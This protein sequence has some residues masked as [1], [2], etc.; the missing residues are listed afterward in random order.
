MNTRTIEILSPAGS[1]EAFRAAINAGADAVYAG[2]AKFGA[3][4][5]AEN[6][7]EE[8][9]I[10]AIKEA[11]IYGKKFY[12]T[13]N[14]LLKETEIYSLYDYLKPYY[15]AGLD[16]VIVQDLGVAEF[17]KRHFPDLELHASTQMT[18]TGV[19]GA[20]FIE[21]QGFS[22][23][24]PAREL[25]LK[26][27]RSSRENTNLEIECFVHG[28]LCYCYSG[29]CL[30][31][32]MIGGRS[33]NRGQCA[34]P[35]RLP[36]SATGEK[37]HLLSPKDICTLEI[38]PEMIEAGI[39]SFKIEGRMKKPEYVAGVTA[40]YR[41]YVDLYLEKGKDQFYVFPEDRE[42]LMDLYN[43]GGSSIGYYK[44]HNGPDMMSLQRPN[45]AGVP[46]L[47]IFSQKGREVE[48]EVLTQLHPGDVLEITG[49]KGNYTLGKS[50]SKGECLK[51]L[52]GK[53]TFLKK[54]MIIN[55]IRNES[56]LSELK[57]TYVNANKQ[58]G[59]SGNLTLS[60]G[61]PAILTV[62]SGD[63]Y[64][65]AFSDEVIQEAQ[66]QPMDQEK[67]K[68]QIEKTG[69]TEFYFN[70]L[71][72]QMDDSIFIP[73]KQMNHL[74]RDALEGLKEEL[75]AHYYRIC[76]ESINT[77]INDDIKA[78]NGKNTKSSAF[79]TILI[80]SLEHIRGLN[81]Y[82]N[83]SKSKS[84]KRIYVESDLI[85][86]EGDSLQRELNKVKNNSI[87]IYMAFPHISRENGSKELE[88]LTSYSFDGVLLRNLEQ[89]KTLTDAR[90]DKSIIL[91]DNLY[92]FNKYTKLF[93]NRV[94]I[95][96]FTVPAEL[97]V[98]EMQKLQ[99]EGFELPVYGYHPV[100]ISA[101]CILKTEGRCTKT[102]SLLFIKDRL[103]NELP[104][105]TRC[106]SCYNII[107]NT[108]PLYLGTNREQIEKLSLS[109]LRIH[110]TIESEEKVVKLLELMDQVFQ[111]NK[112]G[113]NPGF[114][115]TQ[116][117]FNRG[118]I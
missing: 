107:Y 83:Q 18:I 111:Q 44:Q 105:R 36:Y 117:H 92:V 5:F 79:F 49:G 47:K 7:T 84:L 65:T 16:A 26:E 1:Y 50:L 35:C 51:F 23:V 59:I 28:A 110:F 82:L 42:K 37:K 52:V 80:E 90:F 14:T 108:S 34:Q 87:E 24:V 96:Q 91:D 89:L 78:S 54:G 57:D 20:S 40:M 113:N 101:Q 76:K 73:I 70:D 75:A 72:I 112:N 6:F 4:A 115:Y 41:K 58:V 85:E 106:E 74:R 68:K 100:M 38:I 88:V 102:P 86:L 29:Q 63:I 45:H 33:G 43:R 109:S 97:N 19:N 30:L 69:T 46:A 13:V 10:Q 53:N 99:V 9:L 66:N 60:I 8:Q 56:E 27:I 95:H 116:G 114:E 61:S 71:D 17:V 31:S 55:R 103:N 39:D 67:I 94:G 3:R 104:V 2:G 21:E 25:S 32:S 12:L 62:S 48:G 15:E 93:W 118:I 11:H 98:E 81:E 64:F 77:E 22:R